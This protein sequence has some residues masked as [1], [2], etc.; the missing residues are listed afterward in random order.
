MAASIVAER[1]HVSRTRRV[2]NSLKRQSRPPGSAKQVVSGYVFIAPFLIIFLLFTAWPDIYS[3]ILSFKRYAGYG[4]A[5]SVGTANYKALLTYPAFWTE[6]EN[7]IFY[8]VVHAIILIPVA[9]VLAVIVR[10]KFI[11]GQSFW[12]PIIFLP[13]VMSIVA[14]SLVFETLFTQQYGVVNSLLGINVAWLTD[15]SIARWIVVLLLVWQGVGFWFVVFLAGL[16]SVDPAVEE[17]A[18]VDGAGPV[19]RTL[20]ILVPMM[21]NVILFAVIID[22]IGSMALYTQPNL[23]TAQGGSLAVPA[24]GTLSNLVVGNLESASFGESAAAG[25]LLFV[26]TVVVGAVI[27]GVYRLAGGRIG[28]DR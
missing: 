12:K 18:M 21:K 8:W 5:V 3:L 13:Q 22:A 16:T 17:A 20:S 7:T 27:F 11:R 24:V 6:L 10:S 14:V 28:G 23:L 25:W 1:R 26:L 2:A 4:P 19:R 9:F 15:F